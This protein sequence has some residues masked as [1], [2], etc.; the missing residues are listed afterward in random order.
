M[1]VHIEMLNLTRREA[2][3]T[4]GETGRITTIYDRFG[5]ETEDTEEAAAVVVA[6]PDGLFSDVD[7]SHFDVLGR[8]T[9]H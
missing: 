4:G 7:L 8:G 1:K 6:W 5:T 9:M 2:Y 3:S